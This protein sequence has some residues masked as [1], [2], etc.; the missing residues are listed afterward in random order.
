MISHCC[1]CFGYCLL[2]ADLLSLLFH[3]RVR[4]GLCV[5]ERGLP[6]FGGVAGVGEC[7]AGLGDVDN[8]FES[9]R[10]M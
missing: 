6:G 2:A 8:E 5:K 9:V 3:C 10:D 1:C 7:S 4:L